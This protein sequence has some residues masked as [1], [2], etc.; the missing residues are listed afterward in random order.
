[1]ELL[2][3]D[4]M[5]LP[6]YDCET[7]Y[8]SG[9][10]GTQ[11]AIC[12]YAEALAAKGY[13]VTVALCNLKEA[14]VSRGVQ[15]QTMAWLNSGVKTDVVVW[16]SGVAKSIRSM[17]ESKLQANLKIAW[18]PHNVNEPAVNDMSA[19]LYDFD[20]FAF[21]SDWQRRKFID[22]YGIES[23][24][25][26][27]MWNGVSPGFI[28]DFDVTAKKP[29]LIYLSQ[30]DRGLTNLADAWPRI[31]EA[32]PEAEL[33]VYGSR[34][35]YG[36]EDH[37]G[38]LALF[39]R[40]RSY[41]R[42]FVHD[43]VGQSE[44]VSVCRDAAIFA[45]PTD[46]YETGCITLTEACAAGCVPIVSELGALGTYFNDCLPFDEHIV[47]ACVKRACALL[48][49]YKDEPTKFFARCE[50]Y[51][52]HFQTERDYRVLVD[53]FVKEAENYLELK[54]HAVTAFEQARIAFGDKK[55]KT[56]RLYLDNMLPM[57]TSA[58]H[59][60]NYWL[61][62]GVCAYHEN[63][64]QNAVIFFEK[65][66]KWNTDIQL[67]INMILT[68]EKLGNEDEVIR[69][70]ENALKYKFNMQIVYKILNRVQ[71]KPYFDRCK[72]GKYL[73]SLWN[74]DIHSNDWMSLF[75][76]HGNMVASDFTLVMRH[77]EGISN[78]ANLI[79]RGLAFAKLN[80]Q[81]LSSMIQMRSNLQKIFS[82]IFLNLNYYETRN[83]EHL[84]Y[85]KYYMENIPLPN[86]LVKPSFSKIGR[87]RKIRIGFLSGDIVYHPVSYI[88]NGIVEHMDTS[89][90]EVHIFSTTPVLKDNSLQNKIRKYA[91]S[92]ADMGEDASCHK[93]RDTILE[94]DIDVL[95][96]MTGHTSNGNRLIE[97]LH[98]KPARVIANYFAYPNSYGIEAVD[99][100]IGDKHVFPAGLENY[101][102]EKFCKIEG[103]FHT[104]KPIVELSVNK[105]EHT[106]IIF[107]CTNNPKKYRPD[108]IKA[109]ARILKSVPG[110][111]LKMRYFNLEDPSIQ[112]F[113]WKEF[114][115]HGVERSRI[116]L[117][118]GESLA[119]YFNSYSDM[120]ICLDPYPYNGG[121]I[122]IEILYAGLPYVTKLGNSYV[123]RVGASILHQVGHPELIAKNEEEYVKI[124]VDLAKDAERL[125]NYKAFMRADMMKSTLGDNAAFTKQFEKGLLWMLNDKK[126]FA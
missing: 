73:L 12:Y 79:H 26:M 3:V 104:Y 86:D 98:Y 64:L 121:T 41:D 74:D 75:L 17:F 22:T 101:Y 4:F 115:K 114:E 61:W 62:R 85:I 38:T 1:M 92:F 106:G 24:R 84:R 34:K 6:A 83:P 48:D 109:V 112:E 31:A 56:A 35:L 93:I 2:F 18:I 28:G 105:T 94:K 58:V 119:K 72:W 68:H 20:A 69:W 53:K 70:C 46:F 43:P 16:C 89:K 60:Y 32:H 63:A 47:D 123:S 45:Y 8:T 76:S 88:L 82:N 50:R 54:Q 21:V 66:A 103:G 23:E 124:A 77:E 87:G 51:A 49:L 36:G 97:A 40:I 118:L 116:D 71:K 102:I 52:Y 117:A 7:P 19:V 108:W 80:K 78:L 10:G 15:F 11:S 67:C 27:L 125:A 90:F 25:T 42:A 95:V 107:G 96:E 91:T 81:D 100:K 14:K 39:D 126:W 99:Y 113:Y 110:S 55:Y 120:D 57:F 111:K 29:K 59:I 30:P 5:N 13:N 33:H 122:N 65:A 44:L 37:S 9:I